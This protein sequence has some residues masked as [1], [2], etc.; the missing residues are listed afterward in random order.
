MKKKKK[1]QRRLAEESRTW[2][3]SSHRSSL[4]CPVTVCCHLIGRAFKRS[5]AKQSQSSNRFPARE[6]RREM[7]GAGEDEED[8]E[9][10]RRMGSLHPDRLRSR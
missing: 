3:A 1:K 4:S 10:E 9:E 6:E 2:T 8:E 5:S 7:E